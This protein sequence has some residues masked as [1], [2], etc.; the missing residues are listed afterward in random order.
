VVLNYVTT[1]EYKFGLAS[2]LVA[3]LSN[4]RIALQQCNLET[5]EIQSDSVEEIASSS[6]RWAAQKIGAPAV[7]MDVGFSINALN[8]FPGP[9]VKYINDW[10]SPTD[11][12][13]MM[14]GKSER[15]SFFID[16]L[17]YAHPNGLSRTFVAKTKG[18]IVDAESAAPA[19]W[20]VDA[21]FVPEGHKNSLSEIS[22]RD[23]VKIWTTKEAWRQLIAFALSQEEIKEN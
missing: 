4:G 18:S 20:T 3:D 22:D 5:P 6:A 9:F 19:R 8:G 2:E 11:I 15:S 17:A 13:K 14:A 23:K 21:L 7:A 16:A 1:N 12:L 10:L